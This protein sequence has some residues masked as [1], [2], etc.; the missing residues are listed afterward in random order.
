MIIDEYRLW[1]KS[2]PCILTGLRPVDPHHCYPGG[3]T[4]KRNHDEWL[5][6]LHRTQHTDDI[7]NRNRKKFREAAKEYFAQWLKTLSPSKRK[8]IEEQ[9]NG[10]K[11]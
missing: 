11:R 4:A 6:P 7:C 5:V 9:L 8:K 10:T 3:A 1:I 2:L